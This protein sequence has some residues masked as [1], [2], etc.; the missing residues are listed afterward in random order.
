MAD[1]CDLDHV[2]GKLPFGYPR[3]VH[4]DGSRTPFDVTCGFYPGMEPQQVYKRKAWPISEK[5][6][7]AQCAPATLQTA[8]VVQQIAENCLDSMQEPLMDELLADQYL[9]Y[10]SVL[11]G[12]LSVEAGGRSLGRGSTYFPYFTEAEISTIRNEL[13]TAWKK[14]QQGESIISV[15]N[16]MSG[17]PDLSDDDS[18][19]F[20]RS[21]MDSLVRTMENP[22]ADEFRY[23]RELKAYIKRKWLNL[24]T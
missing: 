3:V 16:G 24:P 9:L 23:W 15:L 2:G 17:L 11:G 6:D 10:F 13:I 5:I 19:R 4:E 18:Q 1:G 20:L 14:I 21:V 7:I 22:G 12:M 8:H